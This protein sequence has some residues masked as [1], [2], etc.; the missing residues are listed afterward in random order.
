MPDN[1]R[2]LIAKVLASFMKSKAPKAGAGDL[3]DDFMG[4]RKKKLDAMGGKNTGGMF[5]IIFKKRKEREDALKN[6]EY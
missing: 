4:G 2:S 5:D 6:I 3:P 1:E